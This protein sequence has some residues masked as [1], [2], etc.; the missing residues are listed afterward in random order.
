MTN[1][2][3]QQ[4][5]IHIA[6]RSVLEVWRTQLKK[7]VQPNPTSHLPIQSPRIATVSWTGSSASGEIVLTI[8]SAG[9]ELVAQTLLGASGNYVPEGTDLDDVVGE[10]CNMIAGRVSTELRHR[11]LTG[12][13]HPP[14]V[15]RSSPSAIASPSTPTACLTQWICG[16]Y[17]FTFTIDIHPTVP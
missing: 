7:E 2:L 5:L 6:N 10:L 15:T 4:E 11:R 8:S 14:Q 1:P 17:S 12:T 3:S 13:L 16:D 9:A